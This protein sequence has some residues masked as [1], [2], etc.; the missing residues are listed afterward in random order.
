MEFNQGQI[1][2]GSK[3][4]KDVSYI[5]QISLTLGNVPSYRIS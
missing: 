5:K 3:A 2:H 1:I 4:A